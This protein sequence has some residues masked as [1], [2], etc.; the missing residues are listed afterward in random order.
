MATVYKETFAKPLPTDAEV[1][2]RK[3][4]RFARWR[5]S[6]GKRR[7]GRL[8]ADGS[9]VLIESGVYTAKYRDGS[10]RVRKVST[11]CRSL[12]AARSVLNDLQKRAEKVRSG[13]TTSAEDAVLD[14]K[15]TPLHDHLTAYLEHLRT[16]R[17]KGGKPTVSATHRRNVEHR[18]R[19]LMRECRFAKVVDLDRRGA[20]KWIAE[21]AEAG[22][23]AARTVNAHIAALTAFGNWCVDTHR[24]TINPFTRM[25]K[26]DERADC[27]HRR[28]ALDDDEL[29][30]LL[31]AARL[32][33]LA[34]YGRRTV[35]LPDA[36]HRDSKKSRKT[37][38]KEAL[39][40]AN[41]E[42]AARRGREALTDN[43]TLIADLERLGRERELI[44][45]TL[46][47]TGLRKGELA[48][49]TVG[50]LDLD[51][52]P[53]YATI[54]AADE[55]AGRGADVPLR[56]DLAAELRQWMH[57]RL[58]ARRSHARVS[59]GP[60]P[61]NL[62]PA[63]KV[64]D[65]PEGLVRIFDHDRQAAGISKRDDRD[66]VVDVHALR[67]TFGS[68]LSRAGVAPRTAQAAMRHGSL[69]LTMQHYTDPRLLDVA[70]SLDALPRVFDCRTDSNQNQATGTLDQS[71][72]AQHVPMHVPTSDNVRA[73]SS[74]AGKIADSRS[75]DTSAV[76]EAGGDNCHRLARDGE[77][78]RLGLEP[79]TSG[80]KGRCSTD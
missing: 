38:K 32:R 8:N 34:E 78:T 55:K 51:S 21:R 40:P 74:S 19:R 68:H 70:G 14:H 54:A 30:R 1:Y 2:T 44:Y 37:W 46:L 23:P 17:G 27:R 75:S 66:R 9:K 72:P 4:Q 49:L 45:T 12:D 36:E 76:S 18:L 59:T 61:A 28:R 80:L 42:T 5:D 6:K 11:G 79:K 77:V 65:V 13:I 16:K 60:L 47:L 69:E 52:T 20:E 35:R 15:A 56:E 22:E 26:L 57:E 3:G 53:A 33:P 7:M 41:L 48:S 39:N 64:F 63:D 29:R 50:S 24:L 43:P 31:K 25:P 73:D 62:P 71:A 10:G 67:H 58:E